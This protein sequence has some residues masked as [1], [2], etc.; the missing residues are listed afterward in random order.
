MFAT[1]RARPLSVALAVAALALAGCGGDDDDRPS[2]P[3][4]PASD[5]AASSAATAAPPA[6][7]DGTDDVCDVVTRFAM[8]P[9]PEG[10]NPLTM[11]VDELAA[12]EPPAELADAWAV[13]TRPGI[14][15]ASFMEP[16]VAAAFD[17][18]D[19]YVDEQCPVP[20]APPAP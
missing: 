9:A 1:P 7:G 2:E 6:G 18:F 11:L 8:T 20:E 12:V 15:E 16:D 3:A 17:E 10:G 14:D 5:R 13:L 4:D 19:R